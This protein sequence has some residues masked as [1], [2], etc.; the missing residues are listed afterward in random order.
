MESDSCLF[1]KRDGENFSIAVIYVDDILVISTRGGMIDELQQFLEK[2]YGGI[3][4]QS[5]KRLSFLALSIEISVDQR[6]IIMN[7]DYYIDKLLEHVEKEVLGSELEVSD[8][9]SS[10]TLFTVDEESEKL[11]S[12][13]AYLSIIMSLMF[14][15]IRTRPDI[16]KEVTF[17][18]T[19]VSSPSQDDWKKLLKVLGYLKK[20]PHH[21]IVFNDKDV[22][23]VEIFV[24][25]SFNVHDNTSGHTG[26]VGKIYGNV[27]FWKS[28]KQRIVVKSSTE[29]E[30]VAL[31]EA[32]TFAVW[33]MELLDE[34]AMPYQE[35]I[36]MYQ[37]N[38]STMTMAKSGK[39]QFKRTKHIANRYFWIKQFI[40]SEEIKLSYVPTDAMIADLMTKP[41][42]GR[43]FDEM[44]KAISGSN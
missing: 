7:Q 12:R 38:L 36:V 34:I 35:P 16:I 23:S 33:I 29:A 15:A 20:N 2:R 5:D 32:A 31:D 8:Y 9:P 19:R 25:A 37:D 10:A 21:N 44:V 30:L 3:S 27:V 14:A 22:D 42:Q 24:D 40:D 43:K 17:L 41:I 18:A 39:G 1:I 13:D 26:I 28:H 6:M 4:V 11:T